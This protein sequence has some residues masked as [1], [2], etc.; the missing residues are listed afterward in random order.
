MNNFPVLDR[1]ELDINLELKKKFLDSWSN[2]QV[3]FV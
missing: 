1:K 2:Q 3:M